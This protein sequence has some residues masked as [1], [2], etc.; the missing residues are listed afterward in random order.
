[1]MQ[2]YEAEITDK[3]KMLIEAVKQF[4]IE[5]NPSLAKPENKNFLD[6]IALN[7]LKFINNAGRDEG[8]SERK[9]DDYAI[10]KNL[11]ESVA[12]SATASDTL[13]KSPELL[14]KI[15]NVLNEVNKALNEDPEFKKKFEKIANSDLSEKEKNKEFEKL[16]EDHFKDDPKKLESIKNDLKEVSNA[17]L[18]KVHKA[19]DPDSETPEPKIPG[20]DLYSNLFGLAISGQTGGLQIPITQ[21]LGNGLG[22]NDWNPNDGNSPIDYQNSTKDT[23]FGDSLGLNATT[24]RNY[25]SIPEASVDGFRSQLEAAGLKPPSTAP[26]MKPPGF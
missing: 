3:F 19:L 6:N 7:A 23:Q 12:V 13:E 24:T 15:G 2:S 10:M 11:A 25:L 17:L 22:F 8:L 21:Y 16:I 14:D 26:S 5:K 4:A 20:N 1:M 18:K 9:L